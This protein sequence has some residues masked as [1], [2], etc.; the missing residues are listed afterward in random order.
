MW[1]KAYAK[2]NLGL[3]VTN[4]RADGFHDIDT[5]FALIDLYD[6]LRLEP[7]PS[8]KIY[9]SVGVANLPKDQDNLVYK[10]AQRYL[11]AAQEERGVTIELE[12][13]IPISA[14]L[15]GG[16]SDAAAVL[17][18]MSE[19][20]PSNVD[21]YKI[22]LEL[23]SDVPFFLSGLKAAHGQARGEVLEGLQLK[24]QNLLLVNPNIA[25]SAKD[26]YQNLAKLD[27]SLNVNKII[28]ELNTGKKPRYF[29]SLQ[30]G[31][32]RLEPK[33]AEVLAVLDKYLDGVLMSGSG[34]TCFGLGSVV[35]IEL[36]RAEINRTFPE[37]WTKVVKTL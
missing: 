4:K 6:S 32:L 19:I 26:A 5:I 36:A 9:L 7:F 13:N 1:I 20:Y 31:V 30:A 15:G 10:A 2:V 25:V 18:A 3:A 24:T 12:K 27:N 21:L 35:D 28:K 16:S 22:A 34:S 29:N 17:Q 23:G 11:E 8:N 33:L 14:G 37:Y